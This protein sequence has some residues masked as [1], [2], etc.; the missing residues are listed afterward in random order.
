MCTSFS[1][2][3]DQSCDATA[4][5]AHRLNTAYIDPTSLEDYTACRLI[6]LDNNPGVR[7]SD[8]GEL[9]CRSMHKDIPNIICTELTD[10]AGSLQLRASQDAGIEAVIHAMR[11]IVNDPM[12]EAML[13]A[14]ARNTFNSLNREACL[15]NVLHLCPAL[16]HL[17]INTH[18]QSANLYM[19][20]KQLLSE[21]GT[22]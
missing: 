4:K 17:V 22:T 21:K 11:N 12:S 15:R 19:G 13:L 3:S 5:C 8:I 20:S 1:D 7:P 14:D 2:A 6:P 9:L 18:R 16:S 10:A